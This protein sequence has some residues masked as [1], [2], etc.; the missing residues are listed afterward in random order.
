VIE[1]MRPLQ[2]NAL[3]GVAPPILGMAIIRGVATPV[4]DGGLLLGR[5]PTAGGRFVT[6]RAGSRA[7]AIA[8]DEVVGVRTLTDGVLGELP[9]LARAAGDAFEQIGLLDGELLVVLR[10]TRIVPDAILASLEVPR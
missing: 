8:V 2:C 6:V 1:T 4:L 10:G 3:L 5:A 7:V 9:P